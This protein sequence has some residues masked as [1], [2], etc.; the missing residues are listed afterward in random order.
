MSTIA[1]LASP[2]LKYIHVHIIILT[3]KYFERLLC[4]N[5]NK[6]LPPQPFPVYRVWLLRLLFKKN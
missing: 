3:A 6:H 2:L 1:Y 4:L 5:Y